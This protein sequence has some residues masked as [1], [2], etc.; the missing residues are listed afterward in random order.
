MTGGLTVLA[1][2]HS[3][4]T[5]VMLIFLV[6][7][8]VQALLSIPRAE[9]PYFPTP[10]FV[11]RIGAP[12]MSAARIEELIIRPTEDAIADL[13][14]LRTVRSRS[15]DGSGA[16]WVEFSWGKDPERKHADLL[17]AI[18]G[19][20]SALP[21]VTDVDVRPNRTSETAIAEYALTSDML[22]MRSLDE[23]ADRLRKQLN[24]VDGVREARVWGAPPSEVRVALQLD[25]LAA[26]EL[27][28]P[29]V[30]ETISKA[31]D[32]AP[33]GIVREGQRSFNV[34]GQGAFRDLE[35]VRRIPLRSP[36]GKS[37]RVSD[38]AD[39]QWAQSD[40]VHSTRFNGHRGL[41]ISI[42]QR[43]GQDIAAVTRRIQASLA[44]VQDGLPPDVRLDPV[45]LQSQNVDHRL[46]K[47]GR[48][49]LFAFAIV[50]LTL[51]PLGLR[52]G[53]VSAASIPLSML[54]GIALLKAFGFS[55]NQLTIAGFVLAMGLVVDDSIVVVENIVRSARGGRS[56]AEAA[57]RGTRE[58]AAPVIG[59]T[60]A[61]IFAFVPLLALPGGAGAY[62][63]SLPAAAVC[64]IAASLVI[65]LTVI[66]F[67]ASRI[68]PKD[69]SKLDSEKL[70]R[71]EAAIHR[72]YRPILDA[73]VAR[74]GRTTL[75]VALICGLGVP[76]A[77]ACDRSL[78]PPSDNREFLVRIETPSGSTFEATDAAVRYAE[79]VLTQTPQIAWFAANV[80]RGNPQIFYNV[81]QRPADPTFG[82]IAV[83]T[84]TWDAA[85]SRELFD[86]LQAR[87]DAY[88]GAS[89]SIVRFQN[90]PPVDAPIAIRLH[91]DD[92]RTL[93]AAAAKVEAKLAVQPGV[94]NVRNVSAD[95]RL[96]LALQVDEARAAAMNVPIGA[97]EEA[98]RLALG[99][100]EAARLRPSDEGLSFPVRVGLPR[101]G[102]LTAA[103]LS[104]VYAIS[105]SG[106]GVPLS[107]L[108]SPALR[109][110]PSQIEHY[111][112]QRVVTVTADVSRGTSPVRTTRTVISEARR[113]LMMPV[114]YRFSAGGEAEAQSESYSGLVAATF[115][116][117]F[118]I[119][120]VLILEFRR[121]RTV[122]VVLAIVPIGALG[123]FFALWVTGTGFSFT[124]GVGFV[125]LAGMEVKNSIL[126]VDLAERL[127]LE[128]RPRRAA[129]LE[130]GETRFLPVILTTVT[131]IAGL[132]PLAI[133]SSGLYR[134]LA[135]AV[136]G[137]LVSST[138]LARLAT[139]ATYLMLSGLKASQVAS[140]V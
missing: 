135:I 107:N 18:Q 1:L 66:P 77:L 70:R 127:V 20:R 99:G 85:R 78:F 90:G 64:S 6:A 114:G 125:A 32:E 33:I 97:A 29:T 73:A 88:P 62:I 76:L 69:T 140:Q 52:A 98:A 123:A 56:R 54:A 63:R 118:G 86:R 131:A 47:L 65:A 16:V 36:L 68:L 50:L 126:L 25:R 28:P 96:D 58:I 2:R 106:S 24:R 87:L 19:V 57:E 12:G 8:G 100:I 48:D 67:L 26:L 79:R 3:R 40:P 4:F 121:F 7:L 22:P 45:F 49:F 138:L 124:A 60:L 37:L 129:I 101:D 128:G 74:P 71:V 89:L 61:L 94:R 5:L 23:I 134:P 110:T 27:T 105:R 108:T 83:A 46:L 112:R 104:R 11:V 92:L 17:R 117:A 14:D 111:N 42:S 80:G 39:V 43:D 133:D 72:F 136:I 95:R 38:V 34:V 120:C 30:V 91:G 21:G 132:L 31:S 13:E 115:V 84:R 82:E 53:L 93:D 59:C 103:D 113:D 75:V 44:R 119:A 130:A 55:L 15:Y 41:L 9:D 35:A 51:T 10:M 102:V 139:P 137:G 116:A 109:A 81:G 122:L